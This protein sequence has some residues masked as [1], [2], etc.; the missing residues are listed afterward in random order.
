[1]AVI[2]GVG[3]SVTFASGY[4]TAVRSWNITITADSLETTSMNPTNGFRTHIGGLK[5]WSGSY[6]AYVDGAAF[7]DIDDQLGG[8]PSSATFKLVSGSDDPNISG[9]ILIT[10]IAVTATTDSAVE[11]EFTF[12]GSA[13]PTIANT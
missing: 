8:N 9:S 10:D 13:N 7:A 2:S 12:T 1:M 3:G 6:S 11:V 5:S 4:V